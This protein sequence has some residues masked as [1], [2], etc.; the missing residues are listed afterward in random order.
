MQ[1]SV[2][3]LI[4]AAVVYCGSCRMPSKHILNEL[5]RRVNVK[6]QASDVDQCV[7]DRLEAASADEVC[8]IGENEINT[9]G[10]DQRTIN[11]IYEVFCR[12]NCKDLILTVTDECGGFIGSP[13]LKEFISGLCDTNMNSQ[14]CYT[15]FNR[16]FD[17][18]V[19]TE[20]DCFVNEALNNTCNCRSEL[21]AEVQTQGCCINVYQ[22]YFDTA[23]QDIFSGFS[24]DPR[25]IYE[26][27]NVGQPEQCNSMALVSTLAIII[28]SFILHTMITY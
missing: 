11:E 27:C 3:L 9:E 12:P 20:I 6:R 2:A 17:F 7:N 26:G 5:F 14:P 10:D 16:A 4:I 22:K 28:T 18:I 24:Y 23:T 8:M 15:F 13:G 19:D 1:C 25:E 21:M